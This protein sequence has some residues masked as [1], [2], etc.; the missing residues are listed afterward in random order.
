MYLS[1]TG[2]TNKQAGMEICIL[3][4]LIMSKMQSLVTN[5]VL[6]FVLNTLV[7]QSLMAFNIDP[8]TWKMFTVSQNVFFGYKVIQKDSSR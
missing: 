1:M 6:F 4:I 7:S 5:S 2:L 3:Y 8:S